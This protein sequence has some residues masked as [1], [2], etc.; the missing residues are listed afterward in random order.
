[1]RIERDLRGLCGIVWYCVVFVWYYLFMHIYRE[2]WL[3]GNKYTYTY[4]YIYTYIYIYVH[5]H[6][7]MY[8][9]VIKIEA[10]AT[11]LLRNDRDHRSLGDK[12]YVGLARAVYIHRI[13]P[14]IW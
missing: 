12:S 1:M 7:Y 13:W 11:W 2:R 8:V 4:M 3:T 10:S 9:C 14:Y 5:M 6:T